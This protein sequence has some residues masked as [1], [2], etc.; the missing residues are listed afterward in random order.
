MIGLHCNSSSSRHMGY[1]LLA[2]WLLLLAAMPALAQTCKDSD[3][4]D[5]ATRASIENAATRFH[6]MSVRGDVAGLRANAIPSLAAN[7]AGIEQAVFENK[8]G[9]SGTASIRKAYLFD[10][11]G[12]APMARAEFFCGVFG[13]HGNTA[14][15][16]AFVIPNMPPGRY[17]LALM[18]VR[19]PKGLYTLSQLL[20]QLGGVW[21]IAGYYAKPG[22]FAGHD[23]EWYAQK[24]REFQQKGHVHNAWFYFLLARE[25]ALPVPFSMSTLKLDRLDE[26]T[27]KARPSD[28]P[29]RGPVTMNLG[30]R[31]YKLLDVF[32]VVEKDQL[33]LV[34]KYQLPDI[35]NT[36]QTI[37]ENNA[38]MKGLVTKY[39]EL[40]EAFSAMVAR[41][42]APNGEDYGTLL[43][44]KDIK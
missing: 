29:T 7:F 20:Q 27:D 3:E 30:G 13:A 23:S 36:A 31:S 18:D 15:S 11:P 44:M 34:V 16:A 28:L 12:S 5:S 41:A 2:V 40:R 32:P 35:S 8:P 39:P 42:V 17:A 9:L 43:A 37:Q 10:V 21:K 26:E 4:I 25:L 33:D 38:V 6:D 1:Y 24:A 19:G 22:Q 14:N